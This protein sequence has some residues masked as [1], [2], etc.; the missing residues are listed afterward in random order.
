MP[1][2]TEHATKISTRSVNPYAR[3]SSRKKHS[4]MDRL[5]DRHTDGLSKTTFLDVLKVVN[6]KSGLISNS[7][8]LHD[9]K[10]SMSHGSKL[11][12]YHGALF[13]YHRVLS[14]NSPY[15]RCI[16]L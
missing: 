3:E 10:T 6:P 9:A 4:K 1:Y 2:T 11:T 14:G 7:I 16:I 5:T 12:F 8:S 15:V 13:Q